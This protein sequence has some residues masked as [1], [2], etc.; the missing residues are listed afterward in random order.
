MQCVIVN[1]E[2][3]LYAGFEDGR[4]RWLRTKREDCL[5]SEEMATTVL[6]QLHHLGFEHTAIRDSNDIARKWI[7]KTQSAV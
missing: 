2:G 4:P 3:E 7:P 6:K 1:A 5:M